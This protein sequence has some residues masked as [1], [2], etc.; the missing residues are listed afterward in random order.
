[1]RQGPFQTLCTFSLSK[2]PF[3]APLAF[4]LLIRWQ[5]TWRGYMSYPRSHSLGCIQPAW[6]QSL[7]A[8]WILTLIWFP[9]NESHAKCPE[10]LNLRGRGRDTLAPSL[11]I[12]SWHPSFRESLWGQQIDTVQACKPKSGWEFFLCLSRT[13][14]YTWMTQ[15]DSGMW[16][17]FPRG[18]QAGE[19][20]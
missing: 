9:V 20:R 19:P 18:H 4:H 17:K 3:E 2:P 10:V 8:G 13:Q 1:M 11:S 12:S 16:L 6:A 15:R 5:E 7:S 14:V